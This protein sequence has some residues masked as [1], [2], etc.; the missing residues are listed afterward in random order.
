MDNAGPVIRFRTASEF[1]LGT[2]EAESAE[3]ELLS[4]NLVRYWLGNLKPD[5]GRNALHGAKTEAYE[6]VMGKLYEFGLK[7]GMPILDQKT[8][9]FRQWLRHQINMPME[10]YFPVLYRTLVAGFLAMTGYADDES[11]KT[12]VLRRLETIYPFAKKGDLK[13]VYVPQNTFPGFPKAFR[14]APLIN[15]EIH[16]D[17]EM[18]LPWIHDMNTFV[19]SPSIM[20]DATL[21]AKV[22]TIIKFILTLE[23]QKLP[24]GYGVIRHK[25]GRYYAMGWSVHLPGYFGSEVSGREFGRLLLL[26]DLLGKS[27]AAR[28]HVW[29]KRSVETLTL[30]ENEEGLISFPREFLPEK[31][32]GVWVLG[33]RMGLE[34]NRR[35]KKAITCESTFRFLKIKSYL[36]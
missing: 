34:E 4:D 31:R 15:P 8:E 32:I 6:N 9:P 10:G 24:V 5:F 3:K 17:D 12:W 14:N 33:M 7:K 27:N 2:N 21:R 30:F 22:E 23:Y 35:N 18:K 26:L 19:H 16:P 25:S 1:L 36:T 13:E 20:E 29:Y 11:V 28:T